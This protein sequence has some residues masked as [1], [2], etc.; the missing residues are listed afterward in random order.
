MH[1]LAARLL[2]SSRA[3]A[4]KARVVGVPLSMEKSLGVS[5]NAIVIEWR[6]ESF[7]DDLN[8]RWGI[9]SDRVALLPRSTEIHPLSLRFDP[10]QKM[11]HSGEGGSKC[12]ENTI[13]PEY[14]EKFLS[15]C[16]EIFFH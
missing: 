9:V 3:L 14:V 2:T 16:G 1:V 4:S 6:V 15:K 5:C 8:M 11:F 7:A 10:P 12:M 13:S